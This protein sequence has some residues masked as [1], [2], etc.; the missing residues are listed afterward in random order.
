MLP[1]ITEKLPKFDLTK[2]SVDFCLGKSFANLKQFCV[3][4]P[5]VNFHFDFQQLEL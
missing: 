5:M 3:V 2:L 1:K 4:S